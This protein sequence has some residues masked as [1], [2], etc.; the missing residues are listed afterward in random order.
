MQNNSEF[1]TGC[2]KASFQTVLLCKHMCPQN[3]APFG[4]KKEILKL[5]AEGKGTKASEGK[6]GNVKRGV[7]YMPKTCRF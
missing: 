3:D 7:A 2:P 5:E 6:C 4:E 1:D